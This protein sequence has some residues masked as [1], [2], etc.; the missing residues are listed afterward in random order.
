MMALGRGVWVPRASL[1]LPNGVVVLGIWTHSTF[2]QPAKGNLA[3]MRT[4]FHKC[5][6]CFFFFPQLWL[7]LV[8]I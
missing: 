2:I 6:I 1:A 5:V 7:N 8:Q 3:A 4:N